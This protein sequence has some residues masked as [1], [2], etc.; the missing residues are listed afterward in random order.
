MT[1]NPRRV[2]VGILIISRVVEQRTTIVS[3]G[4]EVMVTI[5]VRTVDT[6]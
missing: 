2:P 3:R 4:M 5:L 1:V 6:R